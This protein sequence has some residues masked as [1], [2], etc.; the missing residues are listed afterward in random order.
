MTTRTPR[1]TPEVSTPNDGPAEVMSEREIA[2]ALGGEIV[3]AGDRSLYPADSIGALDSFAAALELAGQTHGLAEADKEPT[4]GDGFRV[5]TE[6]D[7]RKL[8]NTVLL[9]MEWTFRES[10][11]GSDQ[12]WLSIR[13]IQRGE[14][15]EAIKWIINDGSTGIAKDMQQ[16]TEKTG[17]TGGLL[18]KH[19]LQESKYYIDG[20]KKSESYGRALSKKALR[21]AMVD[22]ERAKY[23]LEAA[24][25]YLDTSA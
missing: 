22:P 20:N 19:G 1:E 25:F 6:E 3:P 7:K 5:A 16:Y 9:F 24:T 2:N 23:L 11:Y 10:D 15:G 21:E 14:N 17:R 13:A 12:E 4:L 8:V 18:V